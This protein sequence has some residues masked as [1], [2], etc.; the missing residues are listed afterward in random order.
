[1]GKG[2]AR[3]NE[4]VIFSYS[5]NHLKKSDKIR[6]YY[7]LKGRDG[8]SGIIKYYNIEQLAKSVLLIQISREKDIESFLSL[9]N[10]KFKK[11]MVWVK[12]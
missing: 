11:K 10:C 4:F 6:F 5:I 1:M 8:K 9:W 3:F 12:R 2:V 7:A